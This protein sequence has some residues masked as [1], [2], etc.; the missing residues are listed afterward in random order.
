MCMRR[1]GPPRACASLPEPGSPSRVGSS[2]P[3][4]GPRSGPL[5]AASPRQLPSSVAGRVAGVRCTRWMTT[6]RPTAYE[7]SIAW[8][9][10]VPDRKVHGQAIAIMAKKSSL[11]PR[12]AY[13]RRWCPWRRAAP[14]PSCVGVCS[15]ATSLA[16]CRCRAARHSATRRPKPSGLHTGCHVH[17]VT[18]ALILTAHTR[19]LPVRGGLW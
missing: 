11:T 17:G 7:S 19:P 5:A 14:L 15:A 12:W 1:S 13:Q 8:R 2:T 10:R 18:P 16:G 9:S 4:G 3:C 6:R